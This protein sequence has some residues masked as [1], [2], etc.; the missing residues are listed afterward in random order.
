[1]NSQPIKMQRA[2]LDVVKQVGPASRTR[3]GITLNFSTPAAAHSDQIS[4]NKRPA[5]DL[6]CRYR[7]TP[8]QPD[9]LVPRQQL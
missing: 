5:T 8:S 7:A 3:I 1:M 2:D 6:T 4:R 9:V